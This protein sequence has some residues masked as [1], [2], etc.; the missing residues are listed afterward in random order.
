MAGARFLVLDEHRQIFDVV[1]MA[2]NDSGLGSVRWAR[3]FDQA[4]TQLRGDS[5]D[6]LLIDQDIGG[7]SRG[8]ECVRR[9]RTE[10]NSPCPTLRIALLSAGLD[11]QG[12]REARD[13]GVNGVIAKP[14]STATLKRRISVILNEDTPLIRS[15]AYFGPDRRRSPDLLYSGPER[16]VAARETVPTA[17]R[18]MEPLGSMT[19]LVVDDDPV[20]RLVLQALLEKLGVTAQQAADY[21]EATKILAKSKLDM[22]FLDIHLPG[23]NGIQFLQAIRSTPWS[24]SDVAVVAV[25]ADTTLSNASL[26]PAGFDGFIAKPLTLES[27][28]EAMSR[29]GPTRS[30][31]R[32]SPSRPA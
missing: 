20:N 32:Q 14:F 4:V 6:L 13:A 1:E 10:A 7:P 5:F 17:S 23:V 15:P 8:I 26:Q 11:E 24:N 19:V 3:N 22:V 9:L 30:S 18:T 28:R 25:T 2:L 16:R 21:K 12:A 29:T 31:Q 27:V